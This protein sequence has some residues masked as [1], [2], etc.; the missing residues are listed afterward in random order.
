MP[1]K[2][3]RTP[4]KFDAFVKAEIARW[5]PILKACSRGTAGGSVHAVLGPEA[6]R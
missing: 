5:S 3:E 2:D 4:A 1:P 6:L